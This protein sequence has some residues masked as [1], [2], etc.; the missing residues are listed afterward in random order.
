M[1]DLRTRK[2]I[3]ATRSEALCHDVLSA[4]GYWLVFAGVIAAMLAMTALT[5]P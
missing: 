4:L 1:D 3:A 5:T 2:A